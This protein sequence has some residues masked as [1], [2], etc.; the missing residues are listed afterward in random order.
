[1]WIKDAIKKKQDFRRELIKSNSGVSSK[2]Y[3]MIEGM[4]LAKL[5]VYWYLIVLTL[6]IFT[7]YELRTNWID[8][9]GVLAA[10]SGFILASVYGKVKG[11]QAYYRHYNY[12]NDI[13]EFKENVRNE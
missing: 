10:L 7:K 13:E 11:E 1:M 2:S 8:F 5:I 4:R 12:D 3:I 6:E 9:I